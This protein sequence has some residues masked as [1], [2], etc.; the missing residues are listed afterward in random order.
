M[1]VDRAA[2]QAVMMAEPDVGQ[3]VPNVAVFS[4]AFHPHLGGVEELTRRLAIE[5]TNRGSRVVVATTRYPTNLPGRETV[6]GIAVRRWRFVPPSGSWK[7]TVRFAAHFVPDVISI[8]RSLR[9]HRS[10]IVHVQCVSN[11]GLYALIAARL[12]RLP[13]VVSMQ[14]ELTMDATGVYQRSRFLPKLLRHLLRTADVVT[15]CS[16]QTLSEGAAF[17]GVD[18]GDRGHVVYN[19]ISLTEFDSAAPERRSRPYLLA[20][21][22][23]V[24][25]KGFDVLL[26]A[27]AES[28]LS[29]T[30]ELVLAGDGPERSSLTS[31]AAELGIADAVAVVGRTDRRRTA[32]LFRGCDIFVLPSRHEPMGIVNLEA[33]ASG[34][35]V[36]ASR[37][38]GVPEIVLHGV[39][40]ML[41]AADDVDAL[42][43]AL[44]HLANDPALR[45]ALGAAGRTRAEAFEWSAIA[46]VYVEQYRSALRR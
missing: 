9:H 35:P 23:H 40:G 3:P 27:F 31:L 6:D 30:W 22:R 43:G 36:I 44:R 41:V 13:L 45:V 34:R 14:G 46:D 28:G 5:L 38:G 33:M 10:D 17:A 20:I 1:R 39:T 16:A 25:N 32:E 24:R 2:D 19:G 29:G 12:L 37:V 7:T 8:V 26:R 42:A 4:S 11:N 15:G 18:L 21:G